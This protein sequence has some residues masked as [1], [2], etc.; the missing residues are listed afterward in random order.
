MSAI[1]LYYAIPSSFCNCSPSELLMGRCIRRKVPQANNEH[2]V[3]E[4]PYLQDFKRCDKEKS[5]TKEKFR[6]P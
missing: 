6:L 5:K 2:Y 1:L 4:W 3:P